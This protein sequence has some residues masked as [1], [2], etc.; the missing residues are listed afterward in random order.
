MKI[1]GYLKISLIEWPG[2]IASVIFVPECNFR[3]PFCHNADL[4]DPLRAKR[5]KNYNYSEQSIFAYLKKRKKLVDGVVVSGGEPTLQPDLPEFLEKIHALGFETM[6]ETNGSKPLIIHNLIIRKLVNYI[7]LDFKA[8]LGEKYA[9]AIGLKDFDPKI[10]IKSF[11][12]I[13]KSKIPFE[14][15]TTVV[16]GIHNKKALLKMAR[17][18]KKFAIRNSQLNN[19]YLQNFQPKNCLNPKFNKL[20]PYSKI[21]MEEFLGAVKKIIP[22]AKIRS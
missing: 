6:V 16:P 13:L 2:K 12:L 17:Q 19:W 10:W 9:Q 5:L 4:V 11:S 21:E 20:K 7:A 15:R 3:C 14:L 8:P 22:G 1:A 18:I